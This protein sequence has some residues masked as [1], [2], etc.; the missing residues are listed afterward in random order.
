MYKATNKLG[1]NKEKVIENIEEYSKFK[2]LFTMSKPKSPC[3][4]T[5]CHEDDQWIV[6]IMRYKTKSGKIS[7]LHIVLGEDV[8]RWTKIWEQEGFVKNNI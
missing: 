3:T 4:V 7:E 8:A 2:T 6:Y 5:F 1:K